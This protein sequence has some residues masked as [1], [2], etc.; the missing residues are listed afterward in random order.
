VCRSAASDCDVAETCP[1][2]SPNCPADGFAPNG[3]GCAE[4]TNCSCDG[5]GSCGPCAPGQTYCAG[6]GCLDPFEGV[7]PCCS[8]ANCSLGQICCLSAG[9]QTGPDCI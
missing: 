2:N 1:G 4:C 3:Q 6:F 9:C 7:T 8:V 5:S